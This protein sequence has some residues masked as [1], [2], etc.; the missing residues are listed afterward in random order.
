MTLEGA[1]IPKGIESPALRE[2]HNK[3]DFVDI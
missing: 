2:K 1:E 3:F